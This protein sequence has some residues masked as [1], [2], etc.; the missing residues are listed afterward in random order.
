[1]RT[2]I[3]PKHAQAQ[4]LPEATRFEEMLLLTTVQPWSAA[5]APSPVHED[6]AQLDALA[7][8]PERSLHGLTAADD[9][10]S[11]DAPS[12]VNTHVAVACRGV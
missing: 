6:L 1:V 7:A 4:Q 11:T 5:A 12:E 3:F 2:R 10:H 9:G 8:L